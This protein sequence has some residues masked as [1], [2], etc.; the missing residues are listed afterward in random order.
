MS[1]LS[2]AQRAVDEYFARL[3]DMLPARQAPSVLAEV[4]SLLDDRLEEEG[5][6]RDDPEAVGRALEALGS[7]ESLATAI[8]G[9]PVEIDL[10]TRRA[11][12]RA[13]AVVFASHLL[14]AIVL[15]AI[16][17][18]AAL[19]PGLVGALPHPSAWSVAF[20]V[21]GIFLVDVG[22]LSVLFALLGRR[23]A[24]E[25][26]QRLRL[27]MPGTR[28]DA[29]L[30]LVLLGLVALIVN[31]PSIR[32]SLFAVGSSGARVPILAAP[33]LSLLPMANLVIGLFAL[34]DVLILVAGGE[35]PPA[36]AVDAVAALGGAVLAALVMTREHL[37]RIPEQAGLTARQADVFS[38]ILFRVLFL[39]ALV[40]AIGLVGRFARR[41]LRLTQLLV[42]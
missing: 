1:P 34:R 32:D 21:L 19:V 10:A 25:I 31:V 38:D 4:S 28:R 2:P 12:G 37:V 15:T 27:E 20:G 16:D 33:L 30:A 18:Q 7:P 41:T 23:R 9:G 5:A 26:L 42:R 11:F 8:S 14:L 13:L 6:G 24:P 3:R 17:A 35:R 36:V 29:A 22:A 40:A 39:V